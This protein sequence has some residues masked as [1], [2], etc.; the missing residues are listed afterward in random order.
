MI[1]NIGSCYWSCYGVLVCD[2]VEKWGGIVG[3]GK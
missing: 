2:N 1:L 3:F